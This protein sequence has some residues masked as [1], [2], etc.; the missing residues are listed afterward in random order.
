MLAHVDDEA[1]SC[2]EEE[3]SPFYCPKMKKSKFQAKLVREVKAKFGLLARIE[4]NRL[5]VRKFLFD[6]MTERGV[7][8][9]HIH[10]HLDVAV[11]ISF[12][13]SQ[14]DIIAKQLGASKAAHERDGLIN[15]LWD[16]AYG[17]LGSMLGFKSE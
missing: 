16:S 1:F 5:M 10:L 7:R 8:K 9:T 11:A 12:I 14:Q 17:H 3:G 15:T 2:E 6:H 13:P 4:S